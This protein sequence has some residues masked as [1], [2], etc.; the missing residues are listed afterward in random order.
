MAFHS[1]SWHRVLF[2]QGGWLPRNS[3]YN[4]RNGF[5]VNP[6]SKAKEQSTMQWLSW[7]SL[8]E[9]HI[10]S[11]DCWE[12][13]KQYF[14]FES[15]PD[16]FPSPARREMSIV[17][18]APW[19]LKAAFLEWC[20][21]SQKH[22]LFSHAGRDSACLCQSGTRVLPTTPLPPL[23]L[24]SFPSCSYLLPFP[25]SPTYSNGINVNFLLVLLTQHSVKYS[26][27]VHVFH[28]DWNLL[29]AKQ[30]SFLGF[31]FFSFLLC[32]CLV[33][34]STILVCFHAS[35]QQ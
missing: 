22:L 5:D 32:F 10:C 6:L 30:T 25:L 11:D 24:L 13:C 23:W 28:P 17:L 4:W 27:P 26:F 12:C 34:S 14:I 21:P 3:K 20:L 33:Q 35:S 8:W 29:D 19:P 7:G 16:M 2:F 1:F 15:F 9:I 31:A 18:A